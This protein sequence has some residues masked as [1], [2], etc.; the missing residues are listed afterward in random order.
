MANYVEKFTSK[1]D[2]AMPFQRTGAFPLD[3]SDL[4]SSLADAQLYAAGKG[5]DSRKLGGTSYVGQLITVFENDVVTA[6][7]IGADRSLQKLA[8]ASATEGDLEALFNKINEVAKDLADEIS[9]RNEAVEGLQEEIE[10]V[11]GDLVEE[12]A[13]AKAEEEAIRVAFAKADASLKAE[14]EGKITEEVNR[15]KLAEGTLEGKINKEIADREEAI[16]NEAS[17]RQA[18]DVA[19]GER[20]DTLSGQVDTKVGAVQS[21]LDAHKAAQTEKD[22]IQ[23]QAL[24]N[25]KTALET[26][27]ARL[28]GLIAKEVSDRGVAITGVQGAI[29]NEVVRAQ[30]AEAGLQTAI[31]TLNGGETVVGSV[32]QKIKDAVNTINGNIDGVKGRVE[33]LEG[34]M[35]KV[36]GSIDA[37]KAEAKAHAEEKIAELVG[38]APE[39]LDTIQELAKAIQDHEDVYEAYVET[40]KGDIKTAVAVETQRAEAAEAKL[41]NDIAKVQVNLD[42]AVSDINGETQRLDT[43]IKSVG[44]SVT[45]GLDRLNQYVD[46]TKVELETSIENVDTK[47]ENEIKRA[48]AEESSLLSKITEAVAKLEGEDSKLLQA[49]NA[50]KLA[51]EEAIQNVN[52]SIGAVGTRVETLENAGYQNAIQVGNAIDSKINGLNLPGTYEVKGAAAEALVN[53]KSYVDGEISRRVVALTNEEIMNIIRK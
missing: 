48:K 23:D 40:V 41:G 7:I 5:D 49:I 34:E 21:A 53:A 26:E 50:E 52:D 1:L 36:P 43:M 10:I 47:V 28:A 4:F 15:A 20:I 22:S 27:D 13:R 46:N 16:R 42:N 18:A 12:I 6:Y 33:T 8:A 51:R 2:W 39:A 32:S 37:A 19:L 17:A 14:L 45:Q 9:A 11:A 35:A 38:T 30:A 25:A 24:V 3:R 44:T 31:N 29:D